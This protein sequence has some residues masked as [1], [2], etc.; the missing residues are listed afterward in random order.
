[1]QSNEFSHI[2]RIL[3]GV[4]LMGET[5]IEREWAKFMLHSCDADF[6]QASKLPVR[7]PPCSV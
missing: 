5:K 1:M 4:E 7:S 2:F 6:R 3:N